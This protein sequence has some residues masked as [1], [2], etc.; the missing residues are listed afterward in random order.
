MESKKITIKPVISEKTYTMANADNKYVFSVDRGINKIEVKKAVE[1]KYKV[2]VTDV[3][4]LVRPGKK[5]RDFKTYK[6]RR[7]QD[8]VKMVVTLKKG[9]KI[10]EFLKG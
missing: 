8:K 1:T 2:K 5:K 3:N 6:I 7:E 9:D 10:D 4:S